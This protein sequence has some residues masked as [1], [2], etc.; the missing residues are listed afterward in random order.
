MGRAIHIFRTPDR[1]VA[2]T[3]GEPGDRAF[4]LQA[5]QEPRVISVLLEKQQVKVLADRMGLL[6]DEVQRRFGTAVPPQA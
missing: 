4:Y 3:V 5:V 1:F 6:L 2:G